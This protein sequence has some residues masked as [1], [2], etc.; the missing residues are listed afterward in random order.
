MGET[1]AI[2]LTGLEATES[3]VRCEFDYPQELSGFF[4]ETTFVTEY[5]VEIGDVPESILVVPWLANVCPLAWATGVDVELPALD[6]R[7]GES[8]AAVGRSLAEMYPSM[9]EGG[10]IR[11]E[12]L[13]E[14]DPT[15]ADDRTSA[16]LFSG[17]V[18]AL[19][20]YYRHQAE[21][22]ALVLLRG[23]DVDLTDA[24]AWNEKRRRVEAFAEP[25]GLDVFTVESN[26]MS[27]LEDFTLNAHFRRFLES[28]WYAAVQ[29]G[30]GLTGACA[31]LTY[32][33]GFDPLYMATSASERYHFRS[34]NDPRIVDNIAWA[35]TA[36]ASDGFEF[37][38]QEK[39]EH[40]APRLQEQAVDVH[41]C[42]E[43]GPGNCGDCE[44]CLRTAF[45]FVLAGL[46]PSR[47]GVPMD[48]TDFAT[49]RERLT[50]G[51]WRLAP[52]T[53]V[54]WRDL[55]DHAAAA[56]EDGR[57][58]SLPYRGAKAFFDWLANADVG[59]FEDSTNSSGFRAYKLTRQLPPSPLV[60]RLRRRVLDVIW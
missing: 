21:A 36:A 2:R 28:D 23:F 50:T 7:F 26:L 44:K 59:R 10:E 29:Q 37:T 16:M 53:A 32:A 14:N 24:P 40:I 58:D 3:A 56:R 5:D 46:D 20:S 13:V 39:V 30:L 47:H 19:D 33:R 17:G 49:A 1:G 8:L 57:L 51:E 9:I 6:R 45:G 22:P 15:P 43:P 4:L 12:R 11:V 31:P 48:N 34:G 38:R 41:T 55:R 18:D 60:H 42:L 54:M 27:F 35:G 52:T 25:H